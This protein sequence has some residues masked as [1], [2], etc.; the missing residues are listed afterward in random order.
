MKIQSKPKQVIYMMFMLLIGDQGEDF[1]SAVIPALL[2]G[3]ASGFVMI[4]LLRKLPKQEHT[5]KRQLAVVWGWE[6]SH[7]HKFAYFKLTVTVPTNPPLAWLITAVYVP[8]IGNS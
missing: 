4:W 3:V 5:R 2:Q 7:P 6:E 1:L 8:A